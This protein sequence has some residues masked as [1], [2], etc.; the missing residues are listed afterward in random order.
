[1]R[2]ARSIERHRRLLKLTHVTERLLQQAGK[3]AFRG[4]LGFQRAR[5]PKGW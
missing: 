4:R 2:V 3:Q 5:R 1:M